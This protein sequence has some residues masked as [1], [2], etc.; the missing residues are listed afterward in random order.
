[1]PEKN[2]IH[3]WRKYLTA[4]LIILIF[5]FAAININQYLFGID[6]Q[7]FKIPFLKKFLN[8][9]LYPNDPLVEQ[10]VYF[11]TFFWKALGLLIHYLSIKTTIL[12]FLAHV[13]SLFFT[14]LVVYRLASLLFRNE[15]VALLAMFFLLFS[16]DLIGGDS[17]IYRVLDTAMVA[18][19]VLLFAMYYF[20]KERFFK[21][22]FLQGAAF[23]IHPLSA[24]YMIAILGVLSLAN[25]KRIGLKKFT[26]CGAVLIILMSPSL[27]WKMFYSPASLNL[28]AADPKWV[29]LLRLRSSHHLFPFSW[30]LG[31]I[32]QTGLF[33][34]A[35]PVSWKQRPESR[36]HRM[37]V[38][39]S[40]TLLSL[41]IVATV[42]SEWL[43]IPIILQ[44]QFFRSAYFLYIFAVLYV[45]NYAYYSL[46]GDTSNTTKTAVIILTAALLYH[47]RV[48]QIALGAF[49]FFAMGK[50]VYQYFY[51]RDFSGKYFKLSLNLMVLFLGIGGFLMRGGISIENAQN[52]AW[53]AVQQWAR[54]KSALNDLFIIP[55]LLK[56]EG[57]RVESE[58]SSYVDWKD[59]TAMFFNPAY[60]YEW[61]RR[62]RRVGYDPPDSPEFAFDVIDARLERGYIS[63]AEDD[64]LNLAR[65]M[66]DEMGKVFVVR[67]REYP[68]L[69][70]PVVYQNDQFVVSE[71]LPKR[72]HN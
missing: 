57:F 67:F 27:I 41:W 47:A 39:S 45:A 43:P 8:P 13:I 52:P 19:P 54:Q 64:F 3:L 70:F 20:F 1:M 32:L 24:I 71:I 38:Y 14:F 59:G 9:N 66:P 12:F 25:I 62:M 7:A 61:Y 10:G 68:P 34:L 6:N 26:I 63:L 23:L 44:L 55:P 28:F 53:L 31:T 29:E 17:T 42:F 21:S 22:Y 2:S 11:Y 33:L 35:F 60:G 30:E 49:F 56:I 5:T 51:Q 46:K 4:S 36:Y 18:R 58:R 69:N 72:S 65:E 15:N 37:I 16:K 50:V 40:L 48:W